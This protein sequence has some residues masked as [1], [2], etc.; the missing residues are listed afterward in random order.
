MFS[1]IIT[2]TFVINHD[3][4]EL[5]IDSQIGLLV[6]VRHGDVKAVVA[7]RGEPVKFFEAKPDLA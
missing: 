4:L 6:K 3:D 7:L 2:F 5:I 1:S